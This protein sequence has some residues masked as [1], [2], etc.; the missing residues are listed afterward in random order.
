V[1]DVEAPDYSE[2]Y[3]DDYGSIIGGGCDDDFEQFYEGQLEMQTW[4]TDDVFTKVNIKPRGILET[5]K[6]RLDTKVDLYANE[7]LDGTAI[8]DWEFG[9]DHEIT[10]HSQ[11]ILFKSN[12]IMDTGFTVDVGTGFLPFGGTDNLF[13]EFPLELTD[14]DELGV[15]VMTSPFVAYDGF[16]TPEAVYTNDGAESVDITVNYTFTGTIAE[17]SPRIRLYQLLIRYKVDNTFYGT[18]STTLHSYSVFSGSGGDLNTEN[19]SVTGSFGITVT[20]GKSFWIFAEYNSYTTSGVPS[21]S[22]T[23]TMDFSECEVILSQVST[24]DET[25]AKAFAVFEAGAQIARVI[26]DQDDSFRSNIFGRTNS[27]PYSYDENGCGSYTGISNGFMVR[28]YPTTGVNARTIRMSMNDYFR[29]LNPIWN[30]GMG[31]EKVGDDYFIVVDS[32]DHFYDVSTT[33]MTIDNIPN[34]K[35]SEAPEYYYSQ[36]NAGYELWETEFTAGLDEFNSKRQFNTGIKAVGNNLE[37]I[38]SL[39]AAG[40]RIERARR[41]RFS[42]AFSEDSEDDEDNYIICLARNEYQYGDQPSL[43]EAELDE[44]FSNVENIFSPATTYNLRISPMRNILRH[45]NIINAGLTKYPA[46][47]IKFTS[48]EGNYKMTSEFNGDV[49]PGNWNNNEITE[50]E[51]F[52]WDDADNTDQTPIWL[53]EIIE[54]QYPLTL[55]QFKAIEQNPKGV[56][57]VSDSDSDHIKAFILELKYKPGDKSDFKLLRAYV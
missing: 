56:F 6:N 48:G 2:D 26:T 57:N 13:C 1:P 7:T 52:E 53:P 50:N 28:G 36:I 18:G 14:Y 16:G 41:N 9:A 20:P 5:V 38:S 45:S 27:E 29:G 34:L 55:T 42:D 23:I 54:F 46:R 49:C 8:D 44:N 37:I 47:E 24:T 10:M 43:T 12:V 40:Y 30:L 39:I 33:I 19:V 51:N 11:E 32:K 3:S 15:N 21:A 31:I 17:I 25:T 35:R 22:P 4:S